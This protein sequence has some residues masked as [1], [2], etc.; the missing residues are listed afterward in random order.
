MQGAGDAQLVEQVAP[1][2]RV[3]A[4][5]V[6]RAHDVRFAA[7]AKVFEAVATVALSVEQ[8]PDPGARRV[9]C[10][11]ALARMRALEPV[12]GLFLFDCARVT[13]VALLS[14]RPRPPLL[15][16][17]TDRSALGIHGQGRDDL[18]PAP[19]LLGRAD[20]TEAFLSRV[21]D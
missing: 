17:H 2:F 5:I 12:P 11:P 1:V 4:A 14:R 7:V 9:L 3:E 13:V 19:A 15:I 6:R 16:E 21:I 10:E 18:E 20:S 8:K